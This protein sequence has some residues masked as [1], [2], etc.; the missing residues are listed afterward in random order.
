MVLTQVKI[1]DRVVPTTPIVGGRDGAQ[2]RFTVL[3]DGLLRYEWA[4]DGVFEDRPSAFAALRNQMP[5]A[6]YQLRESEDTLEIITSRFHM[7]YNKEEFTPHGFF[8][9]V[10]GHTR[11]LWRYSEEHETLGGTYRTLDNVDG[12]VDFQP[13]VAARKGF[14]N[15]DDSHTMLFTEHGSVAPRR[16]GPG[17]IDAYLF[18]YGH[19]YREAVKALYKISGPQPLLPRWA[20]GNWW[21]RYYEY[22]A[23][24]YLEL[25][26]T[27]RTKGIPLSVA[28]LD[29]DWHLGESDP[30]VI[31]A[32]QTGWTGYTW[33]RELFPDP[34]AFVEQLHR[35][36]LKTTLNEHPADGVASYEDMYETMAKALHFDISHKESIPFNITDPAF[37]QAYFNIL[38]KS[39]EDDG[40]DFWWIDWQQ[41]EHS[42]LCGVDPLWMLNHFHFLHNAKL[43]A[44][45]KQSDGSGSRPIVFSRYAGPG[46]HRYPV[47]FSG[48]TVTSWGSLGFQPEFTATASNIGYGWWSHDIG[49]HMLGV[50]DDEL[51]ARWVQ[52]GVLSPIMRLHSTKNRWV[53]KEPWKL[54]AGSGHGPR[55]V[56]TAF[57]RLR[58]RLIPYLHTMNAR[59]A[60][61]G[62]PLVQPM[63]WEYPEREEAYNVPNQYLFGTE[64][65]VAPITTPQNRAVKTGKV[66]AWLPPGTYADFFT[67]VV[68]DGDRLMWLNRTLDKVPV[69]LKQGAIVPLDQR[70]E[71]ENGGGNPTALEIVVVVGADGYF[72]M[73]EE[74]PGANRPPAQPIRWVRTPIALDQAKGIIT[75]GPASGGTYTARDWSIRLL[76]VK[77]VEGLHATVDGA[78][79]KPKITPVDNGILVLVGDLTPGSSLSVSL[80]ADPQL[81][82]NDPLALMDPILFDA[83]VGY[84]LKE[85]IDAI[86]S[87]KG[88]PKSVIATQIDATDMDSDLRL[89]LKEFL[90]ADSRS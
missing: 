38:I 16:P 58:H 11:S 51:T 18:C 12:R 8:V 52:L 46:S 9:L 78:V 1:Q 90:F 6:P 5:A 48:D 87:R 33:N 25:M 89:T 30:R 43:Q 14:A 68:Y 20:L 75:I 31:D 66:R 27:F 2:Y 7:T 4:P 59:A 85:K 47:G 19:E 50:R 37:L 76:G 29:M 88:V 86:I 82:V 79:I 80:G 84:Q 54:P 26:D 72:E 15:I 45:R 34:P 28:V 35:R 40:V 73:L 77:A 24:S 55:D 62:E 10:F 69:L 49:G 63:Y 61:K 17:R 57:L 74:E 83:E 21:S 81:A 3:T 70:A 71:P 65:M 41:G 13:G 64:I 56:V 22:S 39:V 53:C 23:E 36:Q 44:E 32:N 67:G 60:E 42:R